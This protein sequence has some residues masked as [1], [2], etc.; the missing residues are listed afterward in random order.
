MIEVIDAPCGT[1]K[2]TWA[3]Q[4]IN[5][6]EDESFVYCT[7]LLDEIERIRINCGDYRRFSEPT[8]SEGAKI[9]NFNTLLT[10]CS[11]IAVTHMTFLNATEDTIEAI[12]TGDYTLIIDEVLDVV[13]DFN[14]VQSVEDAPRQTVSRDDI[15]FLLSH[16]IIQ[17]EKDH[18]VTWKDRSYGN[19]LK[20]AEVERLAKLKRL[21]CVNDTFLVVVFP[22]EIFR[23]FKSIYILTYMF[24]GSTFKS[25]LEMFGIEYNLRSVETMPDGKRR[26]VEF[27]KESDSSFRA[28]CKQLITVCDK[29]KMNNYRRGMLTKSWYANADAKKLTTLKNNLGNFFNRYVKDASAS[30]G[31]IMWT[32]F[33]DY[34]KKLSGKGYTCE[35]VLTKAEKELPDKERKELE[36]KLDCFVSCNARA[37]NDYSER[38]A[39][40][41]C[42]DVRFH[43][44]IRNFYLSNN[45]NR[46]AEG[47]SPIELS[48]D[49]YSL[50]TLIQ[51]VFRSR[52]RKGESIVIYIPSRRMR[53]LFI[54][55]MDDEI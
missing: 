18:S 8:H 53:E 31:D 28:N 48:E 54:A 47:C 43:P 9:D 51:W 32:A 11:D 39:L 30:H 12:K 42:I 5:A 4:H 24:V 52:I 14:N 22:P 37:T 23:C 44:M 49:L 13:M 2:T 45:N 17:I 41:Y 16:D 33:K 7:P 36:R 55:W 40:A 15:E 27:S 3:I 35:R 20:F 19:E 38:W 50:S 46:V 29:E 10:E 34:K 26:L 6:H 21:Y 25:Y 1:G